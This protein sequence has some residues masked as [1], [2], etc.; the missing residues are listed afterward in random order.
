MTM[1][2]LSFSCVDAHTCGNP[3]RVF[4]DGAPPLEGET[5]MEKR[6]HF[7][8]EYD[9]IRTGLMF[10]PR[11]HDMM[12]GTFLY[13]SHDP[14]CDIGVLFIETSGCLPMCGHGLIGTVTVLVER[15]VVTP[16]RPGVLSVE[17]P[18][19]RVD[20]HYTM[21]GDHVTSV[22]FVNVASYVHSRGLEVECP[23]L[24]RLTVDVAYGGNYYAIV[25]PQENYPDLSA[26]TAADIRAWSPVC[27]ERL[28]EKHSF[29]HPEDD[30]IRGL[31][32]LMWTGKPRNENAD[33]RNAVFYGPTAIDRS[34]CGTGT[35]ARM[36]H[37]GLK[38]GEAFTHES[39][40]GSLFQGRV[41]EE[42]RVGDY[43][44]IIP[45][46]QGWAQIT[47]DN[48]IYLDDRDPFVKGF[49]VS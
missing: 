42:V 11:G 4:L 37:L 43:D 46:I 18:A 16:A 34:P 23:Q 8:R 7:Q 6:L 45:S 9:A 21:E 14:E 30:R 24:G 36:A 27:R 25:S 1:S 13:P 33:S 5:L 39:I 12:S 40:I 20:A 29:L 32:H 2:R 48:R 17:T 44:A 10:E 22:R 35:S 28:N 49:S 38:Q 3:I 19:G 26:I 31:S 47:G 41:E 15:G